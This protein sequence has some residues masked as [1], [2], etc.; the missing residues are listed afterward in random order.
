MQNKTRLTD[1]ENKL[2]VTKGE[3]GDGGG[4]ARGMGFRD[5][6]TYVYHR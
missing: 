3:R 1:I 6:N 5:T 4:Q 2:V